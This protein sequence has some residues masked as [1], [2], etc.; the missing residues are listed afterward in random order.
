MD[1]ATKMAAART[2]LILGKPFFGA[3]A[4]R[5]PLVE[6]DDDHCRTTHNNGRTLYYNR[7]YI[8]SLDIAETQF[9]L[10]RESLHCALL[11][12]YRRGNRDRA[13]RLRRE[14]PRSSETGTA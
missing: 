14:V 5:L 11:H 7:A 12:F 6:A 1:T 8:D 13:G 10:S 4:L 3:L 2:R 9:A